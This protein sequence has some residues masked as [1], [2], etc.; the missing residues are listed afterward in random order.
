MK[1][2]REERCDDTFELTAFTAILTAGCMYQVTTGH[3]QHIKLSF[4]GKKT[5]G[6][7]VISV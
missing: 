4:L 5:T 6:R 1:D 2:L 3:Y 7:T